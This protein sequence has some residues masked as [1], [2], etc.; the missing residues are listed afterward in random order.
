MLKKVIFLNKIKLKLQIEMVF[1]KENKTWICFETEMCKNKDVHS[2]TGK[3]KRWKTGNN[4]H[5]GKFN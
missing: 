2:R 5:L 3:P 4:I 1:E